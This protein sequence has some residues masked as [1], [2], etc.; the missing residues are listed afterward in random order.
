[1]EI[2]VHIAAL[3]LI[4]SDIGRYLYPQDLQG[5]C[6]AL[7]SRGRPPPVLPVPGPSLLFLERPQSGEPTI[8]NVVSDAAAAIGPVL[9]LLLNCDGDA[10]FDSFFFAYVLTNNTPVRD[11]QPGTQHNLNTL[12]LECHTR[13][14]EAIVSMID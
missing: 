13:Q 5:R 14:R 10:S 9:L 4:I 1:M 8:S 6:L 2:L 12:T 11:H 7:P 3:A